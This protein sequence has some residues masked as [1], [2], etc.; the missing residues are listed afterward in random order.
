MN[1]LIVDDHPTNLKLLRVQLESEGHTVFEAHDGVDALA[2]LERQRVDAVI[3]DILMPRMDG[4]SLCYEIRKHA[5]LHDL[6]IIIYSS[7]YTSPGDQKLALDMGADKYLTR[8]VSVE[9]LVAALHEVGAQPHAAPRPDALREVEVLKEYNERLV[10]KLK[11]KNTEL[12]AAE[13]KF[14][15]LV[16][17]SIAG[18]YIIQ[19]DR[20]VY[21]NPR[22]VEIFGRSEEEMTSRM[23]YDFVVPEDHA[24]ARENIR[25]RISGGVP[26]IHYYLRMLHQSGAVLQVEVHSS[27]ADYNGRP[28]VMGTLLDIT[29]RKRS[30]EALRQSQAQLQLI[31]D[32][33]LDLVAQISLDS[34]FV[35]VSPSYETVLGYPPQRLMGTSAFAFVHPEDLERVQAAFAEAIQQGAGRVECRYRHADGRYVWVDALGKVFIDEAG[36]PG[37]A[38]L[39]TRDITERKRADEFRRLQSAALNAAADAVVITDRAGAIEWVNPAFTQLTG[40]TAEEAVGKN[41]RDLVKSGQHAPAFYQDLWETILA[42]RTWRGEMINRRKDGRLYTGV[43]SVTPI[44]DASGAIAHFVAIQQDITERLQL[45]AQFRQSQKMETVGQLAGGIAHDFNNL[46][47]VINGMSELVLAEVGTDVPMHADVQEILHAGERAATL[48][49]Q[50]LAF[51]RQ[52]ILESRVMSLNTVVAGMESLLRRLLG[53]D[54]D[55]VVVPTPGVGDVKADPGQIEQVMSNLAVNARDAMPQGGRLTIETQCVT[56]DEDYARQLGVTSVTMPSGSYVL[57][58]VS[59]S[60]VGMDEA[61]RTRIFEPF[62][63]TKGPGKGTGLGLSTVYGIV[64]QSHGFIWV[65]S[66]VGQGTSFKIYLPQVTEAAGPDRPGPTMVSSSGTETILLVEDN[67]GLRKLATRLLEPAGYTVLGAA[68]GEEALRL[69]KRHEKPVHLLLSDVVMPGMSG[70]DLAEQLAQTR[71]EMKVLYMSG[72]TSDT[73]V[74]HGILEAQVPF[75]NKP[76]TAAALLRKVREVLDA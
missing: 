13:G 1:V 21:V 17:Q 28:A 75:L 62:F 50:L 2:L 47:T 37:G 73:V 64:K 72:Y 39:S 31:S 70:R 35:Y 43:Q 7:T 26:S 44:L 66:E 5:R 23:V 24:L 74:R 67:A 63:T 15:A 27:R 9:T 53:E 71:P 34:T 41:S 12:M 40:Y 52:Q 58:A 4:Y 25:K 8:P 65:Y 20:F 54:I 76:F 30:E 68:S 69:L 57:L 29:E 42:R 55:L 49:R 51:S 14:R 10:S 6:P 46:L 48:T 19:D 45:E 36:E 59:D 16:E 11:E 22:M 33:V 56:V 60:G 3:S 18:I 32:N 61:T 38:V